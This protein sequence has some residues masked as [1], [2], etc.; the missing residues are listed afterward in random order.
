M[1][2]GDQ[3]RDQEDGD[4]GAAADRGA[5]EDRRRDPGRDRRAEDQA[6]VSLLLSSRLK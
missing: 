1:R 5:D 2:E 3:Q 6:Q 4:G